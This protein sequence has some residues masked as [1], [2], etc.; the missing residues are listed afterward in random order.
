MGD[1]L[2]LAVVWFDWEI[3]LESGKVMFGS[4]IDRGM[5][6]SAAAQSVNVAHN[7]LEF[8]YDDG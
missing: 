6:A 4:C 3:L 5:S 7:Y 1:S 2:L 8:T